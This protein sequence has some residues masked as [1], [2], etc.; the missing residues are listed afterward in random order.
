MLS[1][2]RECVL[3]A[4]QRRPLEELAEIL[5]LS[6]GDVRSK[7]SAFW[8]MLALSAVIAAAGIHTDSTATVIGAMII[9]PLGTPIMG[10]AL[11][12]V[13]RRGQSA[14]GFVFFGSL[15]VIATGMVFSLLLPTSYALLANSQIAART[16]PKLMDLVAALATGLAGAVA[17]ARRDVAAVLPGVAIAI[18]LVPPLAVAGVCLGHGA[19]WLTLG[20]LVLFLSNLLA[21]VLGG[22]A[23]FT[24]TGYATE[25]VARSGRS[26]RRARLTLVLLAAVVVL[27]LSANSV[28]SYLLTAWSARAR[29]VAADW[30]SA[31]PGSSIAGADVVS[32]EIHIRVRAPGD[33][34]PISGLLGAL[35]GQIPDGVPIVVEVTQGSTIH[36]GRVGA[37]S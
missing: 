19:G 37:P 11:A 34:P 20:A 6:S 27:P 23:V 36:A 8:T 33:L 4:A 12:I 21:L 31:V 28:I 18:S 1:R 35:R 3:P 2:L 7:R 14:I 15:L 13:R 16:S 24:V 32:R 17:H 9:A 29:T 22:I 30:I 5:D 25:S 26:R 10:I